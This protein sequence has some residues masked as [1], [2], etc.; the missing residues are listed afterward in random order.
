MLD[1]GPGS[2]WSGNGKLLNQLLGIDRRRDLRLAARIARG[3]RAAFAQFVDRHGPHV[4]ALARRYAVTPSDVEDLVQEIF[5][6]VFQSIGSFRGE[7]MLSTW[8][9][10]VA[11]NHCMKHRDR[12]PVPAMELDESLSDN[13]PSPLTQ[14]ESSE[15]K[16]QVEMALSRLSPDH[17][18]V[19]VLHELLDLSYS[20]CAGILRVPVG[21]VKSRLHHAFGGLRRLLSEYVSDSECTEPGCGKHPAGAHAETIG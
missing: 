20:E 21:T 5:V 15:L 17:R 4:Q 18:D 7:S 11:F 6:S 9:Y 2:A 10:R 14:A 19:V 3:D 1:K 8:A 16:G 13:G 12:S